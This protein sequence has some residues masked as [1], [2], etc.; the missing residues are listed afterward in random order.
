[1]LDLVIKNDVVGLAF[2]GL[3]LEGACDQLL[4]SCQIEDYVIV[5]GVAYVKTN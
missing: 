1:M 4:E 2:R 3:T 5:K